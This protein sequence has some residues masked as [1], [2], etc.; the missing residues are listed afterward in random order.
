MRVRNT[1]EYREAMERLI[2]KRK[3]RREDREERKELLAKQ[4]LLPTLEIE[5]KVIKEE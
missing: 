2:E 3:K 1:P 5:A 4:D